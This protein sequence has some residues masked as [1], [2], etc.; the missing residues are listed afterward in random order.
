MQSVVLEG[1]SAAITFVPLLNNVHRG[2]IG[3]RKLR[4]LLN[5]SNGSSFIGRRNVLLKERWMVTR[6]VRARSG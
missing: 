5:T 4:T 6:V 2:N 3:K 1:D